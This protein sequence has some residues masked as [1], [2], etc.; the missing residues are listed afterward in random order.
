MITKLPTYVI[1]VTIVTVVTAL[2]ALTIVIVVTVVTN[3][4]FFLKKKHL[5]TNTHKKKSHKKICYTKNLIFN[6]F[7]QFTTVTVK[8]HGMVVD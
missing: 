6:F 5:F 2:T 4:F 8:S 7:L 1:V 3:N